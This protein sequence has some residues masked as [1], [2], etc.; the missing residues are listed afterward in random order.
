MIPVEEY[1]KVPTV[2]ETM[3]WDGTVEAAVEII[4]WILQEGGTA[5]YFDLDATRRPTILIETL[6]GP[7][8]AGPGWHIIRGVEGEFYAVKPSVF[9]KTYEAV[10]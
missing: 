5:S 3:K 2:V 6:E 1:R 9:A 8:H 4:A 7:F 10:K